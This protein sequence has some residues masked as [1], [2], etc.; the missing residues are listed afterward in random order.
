[1]KNSRA[2]QACVDM[3]KEQFRLLELAKIYGE[4]GD[5]ASARGLKSRLTGVADV[6]RIVREA[7]GISEGSVIDAMS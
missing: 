4:Y 5:E 1:M 2:L 3:R 6:E 7:F